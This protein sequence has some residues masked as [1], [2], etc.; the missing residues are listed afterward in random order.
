MSTNIVNPVLDAFALAY[1]NEARNFIC[2]RAPDQRSVNAQAGRMAKIGRVT[3][4]E[5][6]GNDGILLSK[7]MRAELGEAYKINITASSS[8]LWSL[9]PYA[10]EAVWD[11]EMRDEL[12]AVGLSIDQAAV[13]AASELLMCATEYATFYAMTDTSALPD[14]AAAAKWDVSTTDPR[15]DIDA[16]CEAIQ[17]AT[18]CPRSDLALALPRDVF[19]VLRKSPRF[20]AALTSPG[21][22]V[23]YL[24]EMEVA[25][26]LDLAELYISD[27]TWNTANDGLTPVGGYVWSTDNVC[28]FRRGS[29]SGMGRAPAF[30]RFFR[31]GNDLAIS[32]RQVD[33]NRWSTQAKSTQQIVTVDANAAYVITDTLT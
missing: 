12:A 25:Q 20:L 14:A 6:R 8:S 29:M 17:K 22:D 19:N 11:E 23:R 1:V 31:G 27:A 7:I 24:S 15:D 9:T 13:A 10:V 28:V 16:A 4:P 3:V 2:R 18:G 21:R 33:H 26:Q 30:A 5:L 32:T